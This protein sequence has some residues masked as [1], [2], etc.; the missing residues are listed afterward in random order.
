MSRPATAPTLA[1]FALAASLVLSSGARAQGHDATFCTMLRA[2][3]EPAPGRVGDV[4]SG[5]VGDSPVSLDRDVVASSSYVLL[6]ALS[7]PA[8]E[9]SVA[10]EERAGDEAPH[11]EGNRIAHYFSARSDG[12]VTVSFRAPRGTAYHAVLY[13]LRPPR[14]ASLSVRPFWM[15]LRGAGGFNSLLGE[16]VRPPDCRP[17]ASRSAGSGAT[18]PDGRPPETRLG[19]IVIRGSMPREA[20]MRVLTRA[21]AEL[22]SC[23][24]SHGSHPVTLRLVVSPAGTVQSASGDGPPPLSACVVRSARRWRFPPTGAGVTAIDV[25]VSFDAPR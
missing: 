10:P 14:V 12:R 19:P 21:R 8:T 17:Q 24:S 15:A 22:A 6:V 18:E 13:R 9:A 11:L 7:A 5:V 25:P 2:I 1:I 3:G 4:L 23:A 20:I 16:P